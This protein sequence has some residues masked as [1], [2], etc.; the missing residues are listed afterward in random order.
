M[1]RKK[2]ENYDKLSPPYLS[3]TYFKKS[4]DY[5]RTIKL[6]ENDRLIWDVFDYSLPIKQRLC[7]AFKFLNFITPNDDVT[8]MFLTFLYGRESEKQQVIIDAYYKFFQETDDYYMMS[9][10]D[11]KTLF[12]ATYSLKDSSININLSFFTNLL[13][14]YKFFENKVVVKPT[15]QEVKEVENE[16]ESLMFSVAQF[17]FMLNKTQQQYLEKLKDA[18]INATC[19]VKNGK[20]YVLLAR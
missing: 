17:A 14:E 11:L 7:L 15:I 12:K 19:K 3:Y 4:I 5:F 9:K 10:N 6:K 1:G 18:S 2:I 20:L 13:K 8:P 16:E